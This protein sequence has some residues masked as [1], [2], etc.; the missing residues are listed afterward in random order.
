MARTIYTAFI[1]SV[2]DYLSP[3][4]SQLSRTTLVPLDKFQNK[5]IRYILGSPPSTRIVNMLTEIGLPSIVDRIHA[6]VTQFSV[7]CLHSPHHAP[8]YTHVL[9]VSLDPAAPQPPL[10]PGV[11]TLVNTVCSILRD[12]HIDVQWLRLIMVHPHGEFHSPTSPSL[13][14]PK[15]ICLISKNNLP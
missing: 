13:P 7:K 1:R 10:G 11:R 8:Y 3:T 4:L 5:V 9:R 12:L 15:L 2:I 6:N 14:P